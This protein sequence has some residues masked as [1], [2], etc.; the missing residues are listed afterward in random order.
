MKLLIN[1]TELESKA[2]SKKQSKISDKIKRKKGN[3]IINL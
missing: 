3:V 2:K 1:K